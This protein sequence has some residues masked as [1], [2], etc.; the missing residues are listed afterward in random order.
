MEEV[1][2]AVV[3]RASGTITY[4]DIFK[5]LKNI[6][7][8]INVSTLNVSI[9]G[10]KKSKMEVLILQIDKDPKQEESAERLKDAVNIALEAEAVV[11]HTPKTAILEVRDLDS[12]T[13]EER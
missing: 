10:M 8:N 9:K 11:K 4:A 5:E 2:I 7:I 3:V 6:C 1:W 12:E 13:T